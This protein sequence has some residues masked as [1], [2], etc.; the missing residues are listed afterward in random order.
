MWN[1]KRSALHFSASRVTQRPR[2]INLLGRLFC[3]SLVTLFQCW[4]FTFLFQ[5]LFLLLLP[6]LVLVL[7]FCLVF[8]QGLVRSWFEPEMGATTLNWSCFDWCWPTGALDTGAGIRPAG[9]RHVATVSHWMFG[10]SG[11][12]FW[13]VQPA[14]KREKNHKEKVNHPW[15]CG[16]CIHFLDSRTHLPARST[17]RSANAKRLPNVNNW[18]NVLVSPWWGPVNALLQQPLRIKVY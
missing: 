15:L 16:F 6:L 7:I 13:R 8:I 18:R 9:S 1:W 14:K 17:K 10:K 11:G 3:S 12:D 2:V 4:L 5:R